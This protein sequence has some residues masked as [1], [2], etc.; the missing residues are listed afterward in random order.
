MTLSASS[1][2]PVS[3]SVDQSVTISGTGFSS[4]AT[5]NTVKFTGSATAATVTAANGNSLTV[6]VPGDAS[7]G[8]ITVTV[9]GQSATTPDFYLVPVFRDFTPTQGPIGT[10]V[11]IN[12]SGFGA[13]QGTSVIGLGGTIMSVSS[14]TST[15]IVATI[16]NGASTNPFSI[17]DSANRI[18]SSGISFQ[19]APPVPTISGLSVTHGMVG[20]SVIFT[21]TNFSTAAGGNVVKFNGVAATAVT[22]MTSTKLTATVPPGATTGP[23][24][25][26]VGVS[27]SVSVSVSN[28]CRASM[29]AAAPGTPMC[30]TRSTTPATRA[31]VSSSRACG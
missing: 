22:P 4:T 20:D 15:R 17:R 14:W 13:S 28:G 31:T 2:S 10:S 12:G 21:G 29:P 1:V 26:S 7:P 3:A 19:V 5:A 24:S 9:S 16:P 18:Y 23:V 27:V 30:R 11:T 25:V 8:P 6:T